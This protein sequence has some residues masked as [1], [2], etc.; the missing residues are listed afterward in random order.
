MY[1]KS[2]VVEDDS[3]D[4]EAEELALRLPYPTPGGLEQQCVVIDQ[5]RLRGQFGGS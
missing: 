5:G 2:C 1:W 4:P 3:M